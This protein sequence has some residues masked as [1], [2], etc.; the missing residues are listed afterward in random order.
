MNCAE[1]CAVYK[2]VK[3]FFYAHS[4]SRHDKLHSEFRIGSVLSET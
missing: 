4:I 2:I 3:S 1:A